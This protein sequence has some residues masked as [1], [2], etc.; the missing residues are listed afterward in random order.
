M[1][2]SSFFLSYNGLSCK[3]VDMEANVLHRVPVYLVAKYTIS[4]NGV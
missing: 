4:S 2:I 3:T 1:L